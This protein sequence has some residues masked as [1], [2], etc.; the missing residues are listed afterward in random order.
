MNGGTA[1][2]LKE[3]A[4]EKFE[5]SVIWVIACTTTWLLYALVGKWAALGGVGGNVLVAATRG[6]YLYG[7]HRASIEAGQ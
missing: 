1:P 6:V 2:T 4:E 7:V 3:R 5:S